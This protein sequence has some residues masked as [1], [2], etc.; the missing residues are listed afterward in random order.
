MDTWYPWIQVKRA[1]AMSKRTSWYNDIFYRIN[2]AKSSSRGKGI[3]IGS[4]KG[5]GWA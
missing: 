5:K 2:L 1:C 4:F 3:G